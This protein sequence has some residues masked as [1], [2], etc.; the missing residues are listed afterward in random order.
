MEKR[1]A[2][3]YIND[4]DKIT[5]HKEN[6]ICLFGQ[7]NYELKLFGKYLIAH[8]PE[9]NGE[10]AIYNTYRALEKAISKKVGK[11]IEL[12]FTQNEPT[13]WKITS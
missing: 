8:V 10:D 11:T 12:V 1:Y 6:A 5:T 2:V 4:G 9:Q 3:A 7:T 13:I